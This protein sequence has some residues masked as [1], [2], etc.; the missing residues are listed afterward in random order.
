MLTTVMLA[1]T[2]GVN[3]TIEIA[4]ATPAPSVSN[5]TLIEVESPS[6][7]IDLVQLTTGGSSNWNMKPYKHFRIFYG[8][9]NKCLHRKDSMGNGEFSTYAR[10]P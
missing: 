7:D 2:Y 1:L 5:S 8:K 6:D 4:E 9:T 3:S 10:Y